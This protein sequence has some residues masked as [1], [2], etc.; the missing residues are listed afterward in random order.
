MFDCR[1]NMPTRYKRDLACRACRGDP[2]GGLVD[3]DESQDPARGMEDCDESQD[4]LEVCPGYS[5]LWLG[6]GPMSPLTR[7]KFFLKV[8]NK[9]KKR[10]VQ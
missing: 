7:V 10:Y 9:R 5:E 2:A 3:Q 1:V 6:L 8:Q 4:H